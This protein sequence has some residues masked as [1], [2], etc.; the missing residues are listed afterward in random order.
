MEWKTVGRPGYLGARREACRREWDLRYGPGGW[1][2]VWTLDG[3]L[4]GFEEAVAAYEE[5]YFRFLC[6][7]PDVLDRLLA[8]AA[9]VYDDAP[10][11]VGSGLDY[12]AQ[13]TG[14]THLQDIAIRRCVRRMGREFAGTRLIQIRDRLG[15][16]PLSLVLSPG[17][18]PFHRPASIERPELTGW[19]E[20]GSVESF[21]QSNRL[22]QYRA[23]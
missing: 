22:L 13:E 18:V 11:N 4:L 20:P 23:A 3:V 15:E 5:A 2:L 1:R 7:C 10:S 21:Y 17:R 19:W 6:R 16:H 14:R 12:A 8:D 9:D